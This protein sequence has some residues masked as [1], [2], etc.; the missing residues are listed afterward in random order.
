[1]SITKIKEKPKSKKIGELL[2]ETGYLTPQQLKLGLENQSSQEIYRPL[3]QVCQEIGL[4]TDRQLRDFLTKYHKKMQ[5]GELLV[6]MKLI[7]HAQLHAALAEQPTVVPRKKL[8]AF[9]ISRGLIRESQLIEALSTQLGIPKIIPTPHLLDRELLKLIN[10]SYLAE[11]YCLPLSKEADNHIL[12]LMADPLNIELIDALEKKFQ[13]KVRPA[14]ASA[15]EITETLKSF[16]FPGLMHSSLLEQSS[17]VDVTI[18]EMRLSENLTDNSIGLVNFILSTAVL[19]GASDIHIEPQEKFVRV[20]FRMDGLLRHKTDLPLHVAPTLISRIKILC[21]LDI[22]EKRKHQDGRIKGRIRGE[23]VDFRVST[24]ASLWGENLVMRILRTELNI[25]AITHLGFSPANMNRF[26]QLLDLPTGVILVTGP[27]GSGKTTTLYAALNYLNNVERVIV[28]VEDPVE[29]TLEGIIQGQLDPKLGL[30]YMDFI[31][32]MMRQDPDVLMIGEIREAASAE[33]TI[34]AALTGHKV[35][36]TFHT[37]DTSGAVLRLGDMGI[38]GFM[39]ASTVKAVIAQRLVRRLCD[40]CKLPETPSSEILSMFHLKPDDLDGH[41]VYRAVG[42]DNCRDSGYKGRIAIHELFVINDPIRKLLGNQTNNAGEIRRVARHESNMITLME[43]GLY[44]I[45]FG[46]TSWDE[47][48]RVASFND[49]D[50]LEP[51]SATEVFTLSESILTLTE[52]T[53]NPPGKPS[54][55]SE[56]PPILEGATK[57]NKIIGKPNNS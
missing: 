34:Q 26:K 4:L 54:A 36:S 56:L 32:S 31:K 13:C 17:K 48:L 42:C 57:K 2:V 41:T 33:A 10:V 30:S 46:K 28:T 53:K 16:M 6:N 24:Y 19:D 25:P 12:V 22:S 1:M 20:R 37:D 43:D 7:T 38:E 47:I 49:S 35:L 44:K 8:G 45:L 55:G 21:N 51:R 14:I 11:Q 9:L 50:G 39:L 5:L 40:E 27:T 52:S 18:G 29:Y 15:T 23:M 3:G